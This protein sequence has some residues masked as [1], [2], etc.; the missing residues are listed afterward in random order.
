MPN[1]FLSALHSIPNFGTKARATSRPTPHLPFPL[2]ILSDLSCGAASLRTPSPLPR[3]ELP[4]PIPLRR[5]SSGFQPLSTS[6]LFREEPALVP[7]EPVH[8]GIIIM[9]AE[10]RANGD[11]VA[12]V[13]SKTEWYAGATR[14]ELELEVRYDIAMREYTS[15]LPPPATSHCNQANATPVRPIPLK[16]ILPAPP[17]RA[18]V[19]RGRRLC[20]MVQV[21]KILRPAR[22]PP[23]SLVRL[24]CA[25]TKWRFPPPELHAEKL[26]CASSD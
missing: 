21:P 17:L 22:V 4:L 7:I 18:K 19:L 11:A 3:A 14:F 2:S 10:V 24:L 6:P 1:H 9:A 23:L 26:K 13:A 12:P 8:Q 25:R 16:P 5:S 20:R 15:S